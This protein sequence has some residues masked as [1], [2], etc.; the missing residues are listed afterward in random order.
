MLAL[1]RPAAAHLM[2]AG[3]GAVRLVGDSAYVV[4]AVPVAALTGFDDNRDGRIDVAEVNRHRTALNSQ[5]SRLLQWR[6]GEGAEGRLLFEDLL[7]S[8]ADLPGFQ[9]AD[10]VVVVRRY[11]WGRPVRSL[12]VKAGV[13]VALRCIR[14]AQ[15]EATTFTRAGAEHTFFAQRPAP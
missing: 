5:V 11:Q 10:H 12:A 15:T 2:P 14:D 1:A 4:V 8:H 13:K 3:Q 7:I 9:G 6:D